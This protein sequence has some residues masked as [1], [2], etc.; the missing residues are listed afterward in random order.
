MHHESS[1]DIKWTELDSTG[2]YSFNID[3]LSVYRSFHPFPCS[4]NIFSSLLGNR[5]YRFK[6]RAA[7]E[8]ETLKTWIWMIFPFP[9][10][11]LSLSFF[12]RIGWIP[13]R[14]LRSKFGVSAADTHSQ[15]PTN[16]LADTQFF[17]KQHCWWFVHSGFMDFGIF[18]QVLPSRPIC[19]HWRHHQVGLNTPNTTETF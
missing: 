9:Q 3:A 19:A 8:V 16:Q 13:P 12:I 6:G 7:S 11:G 15:S 14:R 10:K 5:F 18:C 17:T 4:Q 1:S 2:I